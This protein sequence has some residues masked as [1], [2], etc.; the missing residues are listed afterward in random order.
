MNHRC[1]RRRPVDLEAR[2]RLS[3]RRFTVRMTNVSRGGAY[4]AFPHPPCD[5]AV[6]SIVE[7][8]VSLPG[9][10][11]QPLPAI[12]ALVIHG[13]ADGIGVMFTDE[14]SPVVEQLCAHAAEHRRATRQPDTTRETARR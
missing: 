13:N 10:P 8:T 14:H 12:H 4:L 6:D 3:R 7:L 5:I 11:R 1:C 9:S 2:M